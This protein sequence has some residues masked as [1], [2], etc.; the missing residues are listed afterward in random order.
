MYRRKRGDIKK[1]KAL[2]QYDYTMLLQEL[3]ADIL[4]PL[5]KNIAYGK[6]IQ[7]LR[8]KDTKGIYKAIVDYY[9]LDE[10]M[11]ELI[12]DEPQFADDYY[13]DKPNLKTMFI[14]DIVKEMKEMLKGKEIDISST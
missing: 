2:I 1:M 7:V 9:P 13:K 5:Q 4:D 6:Y 12:K 14:D 3:L 10:D 11:Q 8:E